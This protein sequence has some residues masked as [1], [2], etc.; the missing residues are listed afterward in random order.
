MDLIS[1]L[2]ALSAPGVHDFKC[3]F[4]KVLVILFAH[5]STFTMYSWKREHIA[6]SNRNYYSR[7]NRRC[8]C[9]SVL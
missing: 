8:L 5:K 7:G 3:I 4:I 6:V 2:V 9:Q 1:G